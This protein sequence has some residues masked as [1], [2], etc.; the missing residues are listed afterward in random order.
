LAAAGPL[1]RRSN[2]KSLDFW[3]LEF[4]TVFRHPAARSSLFPRRERCEDRAVA[5]KAEPML[6][7]TLGRIDDDLVMKLEGT[8][9]G[10]WVG[11][12]EACWREARTTH[13]GGVLVDLRGV[14]LVDGAGRDLM[15]RMYHGGAAF[16]ASGCAMPE[17]VREVTGM[18][19]AGTAPQERN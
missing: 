10:P 17:V 16:A 5:R 2:R 18:A 14:Y 12:L 11:E 8:L 19:A 9:T 7:I 4:A 1:A 13:A 6:R 3:T 15:T